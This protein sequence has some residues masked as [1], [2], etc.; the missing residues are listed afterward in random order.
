[1]FRVTISPDTTKTI[2][3]AMLV[4]RSAMLRK[5]SRGLHYTL[6]HP[7]PDPSRPPQDT[8]IADPPGGHAA[9]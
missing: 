9:S 6:D 2:R 8:C 5:E 4:V 3:S 1:L 7:R